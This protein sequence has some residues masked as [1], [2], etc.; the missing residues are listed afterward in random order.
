MPPPRLASTVDR[1]GALLALSEEL[2]ATTTTADVIA[3]AT[4]FADSL[5]AARAGVCLAPARLDPLARRVVTDHRAL[6][7]CD[8]TDVIAAFPALAADL[9][10]AAAVCLPLPGGTGTLGALRMTWDQPRMFYVGERAFLATVA[11][12]VARALVRSLDLQ[13]R[14]AAVETLQQ[15]MLS[16]L[17]RVPGYRLAGRHLPAEG[18]KVGGDWYDAV[19][20][21]AGRRLTVA[22][23]DVA[24]HDMAA[25]ARMGSLRSMLRAY[26]V[27][28]QEPPA[29]LLRRLDAANHALG[30]P[31]V[32][33]AI[34]AAIDRA[35]DGSHCLHW[36]NAGHPP[37][38]LIGPDRSVRPLAGNDMLLGAQPGTARHSHSRPLP[39]GSIVLLHTD[40]LVEERG[41]HLDDGLAALYRRLR[42]SG[43]T[44][45]DDLLTD[46]LGDRGERAA[47]D[48]AVLAV[49]AG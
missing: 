1:G 25:A 16:A 37:P 5:G 6:Y 17:P 20:T 45:L 15:G 40:G 44:R 22:I 47:D 8:R 19:T 28:R 10:F 42:R 24:G 41:R 39:A 49:Q 46:A 21:T 43:A 13:S 36:S 11:A 32:A 48:I 7:F 2:S 26:L 31:T 27:D 29:G 23:G 38:V 18:G 35:P 4:A 34:V 30:E 33:T 14:I 9:D 3:A 12:Y